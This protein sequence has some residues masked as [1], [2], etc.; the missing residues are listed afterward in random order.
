MRVIG[1]LGHAGE[2]QADDKAA[3]V[4]QVHDAGSRVTPK[5][6]GVVEEHRF[7]SPRH[8]AAEC[9]VDFTGREALH[10]VPMLEQPR[11]HVI[12]VRAA[13]RLSGIANRE[14]RSPLNDLVSIALERQWHRELRRA[15]H[16]A[17]ENR[18]IQL[19]V[20]DVPRIDGV[21]TWPQPPLRS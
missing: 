6:C 9:A 4:S 5:R 3:I 20:I 21:R 7:T 1:R 8:R 14:N 18:K 13:S 16:V 12:R 10:A 11:E 17:R 2:M 19:V 15:G